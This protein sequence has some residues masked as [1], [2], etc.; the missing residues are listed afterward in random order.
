[1]KKA[2]KETTDR[3]AFLRGTVG[4]GTMGALGPAV[5]LSGEPSPA[6]PSK[7]VTRPP[8]SDASE[9]AKPPVLPPLTFKRSGADF[10]VD[11]IKTLEVK[12]VAANPGS[13]FRGLHESFVNYGGN[14]MP[15]F[16]TCC[17]EETSVAMAHGYFKIAGKP[18]AAL[19]HGTVGLQHASMAIYNAYA[20]R[21]PVLLISGN[22]LDAN[23]RRPWVEWAHSAQNDAAMV[24]DYLKWDDMP[25]SLQH[26]AESQVRAAK[27]AMSEPRGPVLLSV[28]SDLQEHELSP[29]ANAALSIPTLSYDRPPQG[30]AAAI[31]EAA[32]LLCAAS[33]PVLVADKYARTAAGISRLV[34]LAELL[35]AAVVDTGDRFNFPS[36]H[37]LNLSDDRSLYGEAD[38]ILAL[39]V[40]D[41]W[42]LGHTLRDVPGRPWRA[43]KPQAAKL[44]S[45]GTAGIVI[46][47]N[48]QEFQRYS[49]VDLSIVGDAEATLP[50]LIVAVRRR[51][52][53]QR[54]SALAQRGDKLAERQR[55]LSLQ[56]QSMLER[57]WGLNPVSP[58]RLVMELWEQIKQDD[59][60]LVGQQHSLPR[61]LWP[62]EKLYSHTGGTGAGG[63]GYGAPAAAGA[64]LANRDAGRISVAIQ[65]DGDLM[66]APGVLWTAAHH[67]I[68]LLYV[69]FNN[70]GYHRETMHIQ[71][72]AARHERGIDTYRIGTAL[73]DPDINFAK[74]ASSMGVYS[75]GPI[76]DPSRL[77]EAL[78]RAL[79][80]VRK[81]EPALVDVVT[82]PT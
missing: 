46:R 67:R 38:V 59:W 2:R 64:A 21:V 39:D 35:Q 54:A 56:Q 49:A 62:M 80:V 77:R 71:R 76:S 36:H 9:F 25:V 47:S 40:M 45:L 78:R 10:M 27:L 16:L 1:M 52:D 42:S 20:D 48:Y 44:I 81:G 3:R 69:M 8:V 22:S 19:L 29:A 53:A 70:R 6:E 50:E 73:G 74:L 58:G 51:I 33:F 31:E 12:Y 72:M 32:E 30:D 79:A 66:Y 5:G 43:R 65:P 26:F 55:D 24:R 15:E 23:T 37:R 11:V 34:E 82:Q 61:R 14:S 68:P 17:H 13:S 28:D 7:P 41:L 60:S 63:V 18:M 4:V 57:V 75:E